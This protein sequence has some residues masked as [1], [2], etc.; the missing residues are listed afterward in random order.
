MLLISILLTISIQFL[1]LYTTPQYDGARWWGDEFGQIIELRTELQEGA[2]RIPTGIGATV[3]ETNGIVRG[4]SWLAAILYGLP[5]LV[6]FPAFDLVTIGRTVTALLSIVLLMVLYRSLRGFHVS[7]V[8][9]LLGLLLLVSNQAFFFASHVARLDIAAALAVIV[10]VVFLTQRANERQFDRLI[11]M[12]FFVFGAVTFMLATLSIHLLTLLGP[13]ALYVLWR[14]E[15]LKNWKRVVAA[16]GGVISVATVLFL[17]YLLSGAPLTLFGRS[18]AHLQFHDVIDAMPG[19][20]PFSCSVQSANLLQRVSGFYEEAPIFLALFVALLVVVAFRKSEPSLRTLTTLT[21]LIVLSWLLFES[22]ARYY[23]IHVMPLTLVCVLAGF[24]QLLDG[25]VPRVALAILAA[26]TMIT[27]IEDSL[28]ARDIGNALTANNGRALQVI[29]QRLANDDRLLAQYPAVARL[30]QKRPNSVMTTHLFNLP[31][32]SRSHSEILDSASIKYLLL[33]RTSRV[34]EYSFEVAP[35]E[36]LAAQGTVD[37][38]L[39]GQF[40]DVGID[41]FAD[42]HG[43]DT[44]LLVRL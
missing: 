26:V 40:F 14:F 44:I 30:H 21:A 27:S 11:P 10:W 39:T 22:S 31:R 9:A 15:A 12:W 23:Y 5:A 7:R 13:A 1:S 16:I 18:T 8:T 41:Y 6:L 3:E 4:N 17:V 43:V 19:L 38:I 28:V 20:R 42:L 36:R 29:A 25:R 32:D 33:Y 34:A 2:A 37:T 35:L 24:R